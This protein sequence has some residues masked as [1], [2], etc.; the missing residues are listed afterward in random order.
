MIPPVRN[1]LH[2]TEEDDSSEDDPEDQPA[3]DSRVARHLS[4]FLVVRLGPPPIPAM[5]RRGVGERLTASAADRMRRCG[6]DI[7]VVETGGDPGTHRPVRCAT[8]RASPSF[9]SP[10]TSTNPESVVVPMAASD[11]RCKLGLRRANGEFLWTEPHM[12]PKLETS[13]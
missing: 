11:P 3:H 12:Q 6:M 8:K 13:S 7:A 9:R 10:V 2:E 5:T 4:G 1:E